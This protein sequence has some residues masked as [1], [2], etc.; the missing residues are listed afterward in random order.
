[1]SETTNQF[2]INL[3]HR[4]LE[5]RDERIKDLNREV[6]NLKKLLLTC[7]QL[8]IKDRKGRVN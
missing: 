4:E 7:E 5:R 6:R 3:M 2:V 8:H 1:M